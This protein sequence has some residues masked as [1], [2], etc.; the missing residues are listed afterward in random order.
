MRKRITQ[1]NIAVMCRCTEVYVSRVL[2]DPKSYNTQKAQMIK[3][4]AYDHLESI[5]KDPLFIHIVRKYKPK[6]E[7]E[8]DTIL[9]WVNTWK[10]YNDKTKE[11]ARIK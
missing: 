6:N 10:L 2:N 5:I 3:R 11:L 1:R 7:E 8:Y 9:E 4:L